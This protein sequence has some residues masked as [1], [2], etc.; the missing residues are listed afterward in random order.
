MVLPHSRCASG[1]SEDQEP[2]RSNDRSCSCHHGRA[3]RV[4]NMPRDRTL[5]T[6]AH[7]HP[8]VVSPDRDCAGYDA[9]ALASAVLRYRLSSG[10][11]TTRRSGRC[12][13]TAICG[14]GS[15]PGNEGAILVFQTTDRIVRYRAHDSCRT[16]AARDGPPRR[17]VRSWPHPLARR[18]RAASPAQPDHRE[19]HMHYLCQR[20][21]S[22]LGLS[23]PTRRRYETLSR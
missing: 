3:R 6:I 4:P 2:A 16:R 17:R 11:R 15:G 18:S 12:R 21:C 19:A 8:D 7:G 20:G 23:R 10:E 9:G 13:R 5:R 14:D 22:P 1:P